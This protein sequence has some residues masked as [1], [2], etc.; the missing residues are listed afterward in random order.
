MTRRSILLC[1]LMLLGL[2]HSACTS[3]FS[4][5]EEVSPPVIVTGQ[6]DGAPPGCGPEDVASR[7]AAWT[8]AINRGDLTKVR[9]FFSEQPFQWYS[10]TE[11]GT[12]EAD[13][14][15]FV[16]SELDDLASYFVQRFEQHE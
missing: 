6:A 13:K 11:F 12:T 15:H 1:A 5:T 10:L 2:M 8:E 14:R 9:L 3:R 16:A 7:L 4:S